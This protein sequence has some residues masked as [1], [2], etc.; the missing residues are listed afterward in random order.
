MKSPVA[1]IIF[2]RPEKASQLRDCLRAEE[3]RDL[4]VISDGPRN[5]MPGEFEQVYECRKIFKDW[6]GRLFINYA[7][8]NM[9]C[10]K[11]VSTGLNWVFEHTDRAIILEDDCSPHP[12]FYK[13]CDDLLQVYY[14]CFEVMS[15]CGTKTFPGDVGENSIF[16]SKYHNCW[17]WATW[18]RSWQLYD[19]NFI[20]YSLVGIVKL[21]WKFHGSIRAAFYWYYLLNQILRG[22]INSWAYCWMITCFLYRGLHIYPS[23]NLVINTGVGLDA[24]HTKEHKKYMPQNYENKLIFP[25]RHPNS[26][27]A[28]SVADK[29]IE[30]NIYSKSV[31]NRIKW[32]LGR[33]I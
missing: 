33:I 15:I 7:R 30:D 14:G 6:P 32:L 17:G 23:A 24:T 12:M 13:F 20:S 5:F 28:C 1:I 26:I 25:M 27:T 29:W 9:G 16:F 21:L 19:D 8:E 4:Y 3:K 10:K 31:K 2:N 22:K 18:K 11:R